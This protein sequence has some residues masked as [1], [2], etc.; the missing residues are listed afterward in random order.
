VVEI[1]A[2]D[3]VI[4]LGDVDTFHPHWARIYGG[5]APCRS[6]RGEFYLEQEDAA[7]WQL[8]MEMMQVEEQGNVVK[9]NDQPLDPKAIPLRGKVDFASSWTTTFLDIPPGVLRPGLNVIEV[10][11]SPRWPVYQDVHASFESL[12]FRRLRLKRAGVN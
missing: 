4:R 7:R 3:V 12:Q 6:W 1:L 10:L 9:I 11:D 2:P 5:Q 8:T